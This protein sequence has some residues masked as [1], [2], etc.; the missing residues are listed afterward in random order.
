[1]EL[2][3]LNER[4]IFTCVCVR[5]QTRKSIMLLLRV[6]KE[7]RWVEKQQQQPSRPLHSLQREAAKTMKP[8]ETQTNERRAAP[9]RQPHCP[10]NVNEEY[11]MTDVAKGEENGHSTFT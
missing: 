11:M 6:M 10:R 3:S 1:M 2:I 9:D 7:R 5:K 4:G 8:D